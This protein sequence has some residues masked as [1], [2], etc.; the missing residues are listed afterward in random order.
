MSE[1]DRPEDDDRGEAGSA[2]L[3]PTSHLRVFRG[4]RSRGRRTRLLRGMPAET[5]ARL[6]ALERRVEEALGTGAVGRDFSGGRELL[7][8]VL[9]QAFGVVAGARR[10]RPAMLLDAMPVGADRLLGLLYHYWWRVQAVGLERV[11]EH[12]GVI[13]AVNRSGALLPYEPLMLRHALIVDHPAHRAARPLLD[14]WIMHLPLIGQVLAAEGAVRANAKNARRLLARDEPVIVYPE[15]EQ[16]VAKSFRERYRLARFERAGFA[17]LAIETRAPIVPVAVIGA[18]EIHPVIA[19]LDRAG[20]F[21]GLPTLP[22]T[23]TFPWLGLAGLVPLPTKWTLLVGEP[24]DV[25]KRYTPDDAS[26][27]KAVARLSDQVR[28]RLQALVLEG[29]RRRRSI[30]RA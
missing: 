28:E 23:P 10:V 5:M 6:A 2:P 22:L 8:A 17:R 16:A 15:G 1:P 13:L 26:D 4:G 20:R 19:R 21:V 12:G 30:F 3:D 27:A 29:L 9:D 11:P 25:A 7:S 14:D 18:E 24:L